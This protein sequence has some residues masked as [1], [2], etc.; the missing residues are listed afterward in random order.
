MQAGTFTPPNDLKSGK[1]FWVDV[2]GIRS[3]LGLQE[4][5]YMVQTATE[6]E[7]ECRASQR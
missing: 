6:A 7:G 4:G 2:V 3:W 5:R 1:A